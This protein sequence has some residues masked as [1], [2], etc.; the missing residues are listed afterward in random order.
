MQRHWTE[1]LETLT[2]HNLFP[3]SMRRILLWGPPGTG[4]SAWARY[5]FGEDRVE[6]IPMHQEQ[7]AEDLIGSWSLRADG[8]GGTDTRWI[9]GAAARAFRNGSILVLDEI[10]AHSDDA[11]TTL[12]AILDDPGQAVLT[13]PTETIRPAD[14]FAIVATSNEPPSALTPALL[15]RFDLC[16]LCAEPAPGILDQYPPECRAFMQRTYRDKS[17]QIQPWVPA[18]TC[19]NMR[20]FVS[21]ARTL[22]PETAAALVYGKNGPDILSALAM[23][24]GE[25]S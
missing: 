14:G 18:P 25:D 8:H 23:H 16:L 11:R 2:T 9:D 12:H 21:L 22:D 10:D 13:L 6:R 3:G 1:T 17:A 24:A 19:R 5:A 4:K 20:S 7:P 15:D